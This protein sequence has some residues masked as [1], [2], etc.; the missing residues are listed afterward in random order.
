MDKSRWPTIWRCNIW[1]AAII[2]VTIHRSKVCLRVQRV[3]L[4]HKLWIH[5]A[6]A[7]KSMAY[8]LISS[9]RRLKLH[10]IVGRTF[11][12][13]Y[14]FNRQLWL[15]YKI[16][17][18]SM[19]RMRVMPK[20]MPIKIRGVNFCRKFLSVKQQKSFPLHLAKS[21]KFL[22]TSMTRSKYCFKLE[23]ICNTRSSI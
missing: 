2:M 12:I 19:I 4:A 22:K 5:M 6:N 15:M 18:S 21:L 11:L 17:L 23:L 16:S 10:R 1:L 7:S 8:I 13:W 14:L 9:L 20:R 3:I